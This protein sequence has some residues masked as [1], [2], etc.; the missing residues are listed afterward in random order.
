MDYVKNA[1]LIGFFSLFVPLSGMEPIVSVG[2]VEAKRLYFLVTGIYDACITFNRGVIDYNKAPS[3]KKLMTMNYRLKN[4]QGRIKEVAD[5]GVAELNFVYFEA[6]H[7]LLSQST[8]LSVALIEY[9]ILARLYSSE[10]KSALP[11]SLVE[12]MTK[13]KQRIYMLQKDLGALE[14]GYD[15]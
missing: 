7:G 9:D 8:L 5:L 13:S 12:D 2:D 6:P 1:L 10:F 14:K 3:N 11:E 15:L 4:V